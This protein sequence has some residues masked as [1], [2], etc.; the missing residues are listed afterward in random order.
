MVSQI[1][2]A[3]TCPF[4]Q[5]LSNDVSCL[6]VFAT[7]GFFRNIAAFDS[8]TCASNRDVV[9]STFSGNPSGWFFSQDQWPFFVVAKDFSWHAG[10]PCDYRSVGSSHDNQGEKDAGTLHERI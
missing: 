9:Y 8:D 3:L 2:M 7:D 4:L 6:D 1:K 5:G 10:K